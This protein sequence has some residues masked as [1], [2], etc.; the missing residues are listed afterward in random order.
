MVGDATTI[1]YRSGFAAAW[2]ARR[3]LTELG[4]SLEALADV[5]PRTAD[6]SVEN[7]FELGDGVL[8]VRFPIASRLASPW[9]GH[10]VEVEVLS[11]RG[12]EKLSSL[13]LHALLIAPNQTDLDAP[14][15]FHDVITSNSINT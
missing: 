11:G 7:D 5:L 1:S 4:G 15:A 9:L 14:R 10:D 13:L 6:G 3:L 8:R 2:E 12:P